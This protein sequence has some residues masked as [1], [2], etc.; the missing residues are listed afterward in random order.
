ML[1]ILN[2]LKSGS[3]ETKFAL[4]VSYA[5]SL[6]VPSK[7]SVGTSKAV[8]PTGCCMILFQTFQYLQWQ[9]DPRIREEMKAPESPLNLC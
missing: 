4:H 3:L 6:L 2:E 9:E 7:V 1:G 8:L 5:Y